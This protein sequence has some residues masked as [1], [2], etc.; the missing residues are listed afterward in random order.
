MCVICSSSCG[1]FISVHNHYLQ[2]FVYPGTYHSRMIIL[3]SQQEVVM[4]K[5]QALIV[6]CSIFEL[7]KSNVSQLLCYHRSQYLLLK[8]A[9]GSLHINES[10]SRYYYR[11]QILLLFT[12]R[13]SSQVQLIFII[14]G[15]KPPTPRLQVHCPKP[16]HCYIP[17]RK[18]IF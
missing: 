7:H 6:N 9:P 14:R 8:T 10:F 13:S 5:P 1:L 18:M 11:I 12:Q 3:L 17:K 15:V 16:L 4:I 2:F